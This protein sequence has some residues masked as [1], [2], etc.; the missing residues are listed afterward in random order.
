[1]LQF[2]GLLRVRHDL[3]TEQ[4]QKGHIL[5][6]EENITSLNIYALNIEALKYINK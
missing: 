1:M 5:L 3:V 2:M 4:Q 6:N